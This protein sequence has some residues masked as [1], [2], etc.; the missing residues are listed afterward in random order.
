M[1]TFQKFN[2][3][4]REKKGGRSESILMASSCRAGRTGETENQTV[5]VPKS[6]K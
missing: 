1:K 6:G 3:S 2:G 4:K 5:S